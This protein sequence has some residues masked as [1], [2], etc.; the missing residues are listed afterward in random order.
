MEEV[1]APGFA[2]PG[3]GD[4]LPD[5][6]GARSAQLPHNGLEGD[7]FALEEKPSRP[8][9]RRYVVAPRLD[10]LSLEMAEDE[11]DPEKEEID[12]VLDFVESV[13]TRLQRFG[14]IEVVGQS[15]EDIRQKLG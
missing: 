7:E 6:E 2:D 1:A 9:G 8:E 3:V 14:G 13:E 5:L 10:D 15:P 4:E 12:G 11:V